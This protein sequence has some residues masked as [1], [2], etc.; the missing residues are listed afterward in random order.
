VRKGC[1]SACH[2]RA[3]CTWYQYAASRLPIV[4]NCVP[5]CLTSVLAPS[6]VYPC[7]FRPASERSFPLCL[8]VL[9]VCFPGGIAAALSFVSHSPCHQRVG[10]S[11]SACL[12][13]GSWSS[14]SAS[15]PF[16]SFVVCSTC[17]GVS[18]T[19]SSRAAQVARALGMREE[20]GAYELE[21]PYY[22]FQ[23]LFVHTHHH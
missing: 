10:C 13:P 14:S 2:L 3:R 11:S 8:S 18:L 22:Q 5:L 7:F 16:L 6:A 20:W 23:F 15:T 1:T 19:T 21:R 9:C 4:A 12:P 17:S